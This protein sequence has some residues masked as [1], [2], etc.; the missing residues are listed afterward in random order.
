MV[1]QVV[2]SIF[3]NAGGTPAVTSSTKRGPSKGPKALPDGKKR[4]DNFDFDDVSLEYLS[5]EYGSSLEK[6]PGIT[7]ISVISKAGSKRNKANR[8]KLRA[9][10]TL[11]RRSMAAT[12]HVIT[13]GKDKSGRMR[14]MGAGVSSTMVKK[15]ALVLKKNEE[16]RCENTTTNSK[17]DRLET[18]LQM[19]KD[20]I[21]ASHP[22]SQTQRNP[23]SETPTVEVPLRQ[24]SQVASGEIVAVNPQ[25]IVHGRPM[26]EGVFKILLTEVVDSEARVFFPN[27]FASTLG[28]VVHNHWALIYKLGGID[29]RVIE[30]F[31]K[32]VAEMNKRSFNNGSD[33]F[34]VGPEMVVGWYHSHPGFGCWLSGVDINTQQWYHPSRVLTLVYQP[35]ALGTL[36][37]LAYNEAKINTRKRNLLGYSL[38]FLSSLVVL[39]VDL[40]TS[41]KG[42]LRTF[43]AICAMSGAFGVADAHVQGGMIGD[44]SL[45]CPEFIQSFLAG[46]AASGAI[47]SALRLITKA[48]FENSTDGLRMGA[49]LFFAISTV[50]E[51]SCVLLYAFVFP[52]LPIVKHYRSKAASEGSQT[53]TADLAA[54]GIQAL[55][56]EG[57]LTY[58][59]S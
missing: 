17:L 38:F 22:A 28:E 39:V 8:S 56:N 42:G 21:V 58:S 37:I 59:V 36:A 29:K 51:F 46:L 52:K 3:S 26:G 10:N 13:L 15:T 33:G 54:G 40:A 27:D 44:L 43:I 30:R 50:F 53:V 24:P 47:T 23:V 57:V 19:V 49:R 25:S 14:G 1:V 6:S 31:E 35:F 7:C 41:G 12:R 34:D 11:G 5:R 4:K 45:M 48:A 18:E 55:P 9:P 2:F 16:L 20:M 32:E